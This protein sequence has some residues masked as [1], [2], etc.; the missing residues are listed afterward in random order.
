MLYITFLVFRSKKKR[1]TVALQNMF[2]N[3]VKKKLVFCNDHQ[4]LVDKG[5]IYRFLI[6][7]RLSIKNISV[8]ISR[9]FNFT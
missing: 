6:L 7:K 4:L 3:D 9:C 8:R 1:L 5:V 2:L